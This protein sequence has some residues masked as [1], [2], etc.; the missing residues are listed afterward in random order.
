M[1]GKGPNSS[2][3]FS[4]AR[5]RKQQSSPA[6]RISTNSQAAIAKSKQNDG[7]SQVDL[8]IDLRLNALEMGFTLYFPHHFSCLR[9]GQIFVNSRRAF[10]VLAKRQRRQENQDLDW[11]T[12]LHDQTQRQ[13][14]VKAEKL[15]SVQKCNRSVDIGDSS[16][17]LAVASLVGL[18]NTITTGLIAELKIAARTRP[19]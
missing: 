11:A 19:S 5:R 15:I 10:A 9:A 13:S 14:K 8:L 1:R 12:W 7:H 4:P 3:V 16:T 6:V 2:N 17:G 18:R